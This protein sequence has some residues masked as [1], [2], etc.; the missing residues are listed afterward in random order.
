MYS[1]PSGSSLLSDKIKTT[2]T[3]HSPDPSLSRRFPLV[4]D[5]QPFV[6]LPDTNR[7][8]DTYRRSPADDSFLSSV[9]SPIRRGSGYASFQVIL[10]LENISNLRGTLRG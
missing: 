6:S 4:R 8:R 10:T 2:V 5:T 9:I 3:V 7:R 1:I